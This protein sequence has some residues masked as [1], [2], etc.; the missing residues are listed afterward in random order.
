MLKL[1]DAGAYMDFRKS[2]NRKLKAKAMQV[3]KE[4]WL[5]NKMAKSLF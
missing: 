5:L 2:L 1:Q 4:N 3:L